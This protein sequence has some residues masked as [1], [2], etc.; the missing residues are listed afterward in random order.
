MPINVDLLAKELTRT[1]TQY[2]NEVEE[3]L[4]KA[5]D[6]V[7][8]EG[9]VTLKSTSPIRKGRYAKGWRRKKTRNGY[10]IHNATPHYRLT[11]LLEKGHAKRGGG[12]VAARP[13]IQPVEEKMIKDYEKRVERAIKK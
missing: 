10:I 6:D 7:V 5:Q 8:K 3:E 13:H 12:R 2:T 4:E 11:H 9:L 1:L